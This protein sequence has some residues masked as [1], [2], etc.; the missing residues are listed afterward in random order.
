[1]YT[2]YVIRLIIEYYNLYSI[3]ND[4]LYI[5]IDIIM[6][7]TLNLCLNNIMFHVCLQNVFLSITFYYSVDV[8]DV[9][10]L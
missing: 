4:Y 1:M 3:I 5:E 8:I 2:Y 6:H 10:N 9:H 7:Y